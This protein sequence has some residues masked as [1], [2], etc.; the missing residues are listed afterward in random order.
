VVASIYR[1]IFLRKTKVIAVVGSVGKTTTK[2][3]LDA[4]LGEGI[5][6]HSIRNYGVGLA[7]NLLRSRP[8]HPYSVLEIAIAGPGRMASYA[9]MILPDVV[10][11]SAIKSDHNRSF[12][13]L[14]AT[15]EE[16]VKMLR[17]LSAESIAVLNGDD[18][19]VMWMATQTKA[20]I[21]TFGLNPTH[22]V[23]ATDIQ[24]NWP[25]G[26]TFR[27]HAA[28]QVRTVQSRVF[29]IHMV[30]PIL[31]AFTVALSEGLNL[32]EAIPRLQPLE[33]PPGRLQKM[34]L[35]SGAVLLCD[36]IKGSQESILAAL[37][38]FSAI[39]AKRHI[40]VLGDVHE[41]YGNAGPIYRELG[42]RVA[43]VA[44]RAILI[45]SRSLKMLVTGA[46]RSGMNRSAITRVGT[47]TDQ[48]IQWLREEVQTG[49]VVL[50]TGSQSQRLGRIPLALMDWDVRCHVKYCQ[51]R[52][53]SCDECPL[54]SQGP[55]AFDNYFVRLLTR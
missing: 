32:D 23:F 13:T 37:D 53:E 2:K 52:V 29:G 6:P 27:L 8:R 49:D 46:T 28:N 36:D 34:L 35:P 43:E 33:S 3:G 25:H 41:P 24:M 11:V 40:V 31:A 15:R 51:V 12:P 38:T 42:K 26:T 30:Y 17:A 55:E 54:L 21:R 10:V 9:K 50:I 16:K 14:E 48:A 45:G 19:N 4:V 18:P 5:T 39:P 1:R 47:R 44:D 20:R 22:D 7:L